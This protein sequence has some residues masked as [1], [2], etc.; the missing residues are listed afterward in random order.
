MK[1]ID[2]LSVPIDY[3]CR[4]CKNSN[5]SGSY[6]SCNIRVNDFEIY[7][8]YDYDLTSKKDLNKYPNR[9]K[10]PIQVNEIRGGSGKFIMCYDYETK[11]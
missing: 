2:K 3:D 5:W 6:Y 8:N 4:D 10:Y 9:E 7:Y 11:E 1:I